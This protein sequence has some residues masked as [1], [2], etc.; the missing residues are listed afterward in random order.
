VDEAGSLLFDS[1]QASLDL[2][3]TVD[4]LR[5]TGALAVSPDGKY[6]ATLRYDNS[7]VL[8]TPLVDGI[9]DLANR[10]TN[11]FFTTVAA[12]RAIAYDAAGNLHVASSGHA[13]YR[14]FSA[15]GTTV[16]TTGS[17][18]TFS[19]TVPPATVTVAA[20]VDTTAEG[21]ATPGEFTITRAGPTTAGTSRSTR[22]AG[23]GP[24]ALRA[25]SP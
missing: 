10:T 14:V 6:L 1:R 2:G 17:D 13:L 20:T 9:P 23:A 15:G 8:V 16:A 4:A 7:A 3:E 25:F 19:V 18:G 12:G 11:V 21:S 22:S 24:G 5:E